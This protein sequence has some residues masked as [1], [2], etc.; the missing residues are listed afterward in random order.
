LP[1][2]FGPF[3]G[4]S[5]GIAVGAVVAVVA[6]LLV[7][8][9]GA[10]LVLVGAV[11]GVLLWKGGLNASRTAARVKTP[12]TAAIPTSLLVRPGWMVD[13]GAGM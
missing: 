1:F 12:K 2:F 13:V 7:G 6:G 5:A 11:S 3:P 9:G 8:G 4:C 10:V